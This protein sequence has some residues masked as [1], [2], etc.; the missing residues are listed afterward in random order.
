MIKARAGNVVIL[1]LE[2]RNVELL[3]EGKPMYI[4]LAELGL[5]DIGIVIM[6]GDTPD[7]IVARIE[8]TT[9]LKV[10]EIDPVNELPV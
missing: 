4:K 9:G 10:P 5:P 6:Y 1:G 2:A 8:S 3:K 7:Q